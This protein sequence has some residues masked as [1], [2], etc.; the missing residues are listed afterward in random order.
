MRIGF[1]DALRVCTLY[2]YILTCPGQTLNLWEAS[3]FGLLGACF[4]LDLGVRVSRCWF[5]LIWELGFLGA[6]FYEFRV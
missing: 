5:F 1:R 3:R 6:C 2:L 4:F